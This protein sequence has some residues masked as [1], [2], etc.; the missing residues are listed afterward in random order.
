MSTF[1][2]SRLVKPICTVPPVS[3]PRSR[4]SSGVPRLDEVIVVT[5]P[6]GALT[7]AGSLICPAPS[8]ST[9]TRLGYTSA[10]PRGS[11]TQRLQRERSA[12][13]RHD[14]ATAALTRG[15]ALSHAVVV[16]GIA[17]RC[18][19]VRAAGRSPRRGAANTSAQQ[20]E[21]KHQA[22]TPELR[23]R[24]GDRAQVRV[25]TARL[26]LK[27][28]SHTPRSLTHPLRCRRSQRSSDTP[29]RGR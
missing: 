16:N 23:E 4:S 28:L 27:H 3:R 1:V 11:V 18:R 24:R 9:R 29:R 19:G 14:R 21:H 26:D 15:D 8:L 7:S 10:L 5:P 6:P 22:P 25:D 2:P 13:G 20:H 17:D 12:T